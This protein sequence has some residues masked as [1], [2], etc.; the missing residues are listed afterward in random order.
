L[1][2]L[3]GERGLGGQHACYFNLEKFIPKT[4][5]KGS[6]S[7]DTQILEH[8]TTNQKVDRA[9]HAS[10]PVFCLQVPATGAIN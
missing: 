10:G 9:A 5:T 8:I 2:L 1:G 4:K 6:H 7:P 3:F